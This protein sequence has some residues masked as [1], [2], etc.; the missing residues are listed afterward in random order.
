VIEPLE[1][2]ANTV[3]S[4]ID[5]SVGVCSDIRLCAIGNKVCHV[6]PFRLRAV[7]IIGCHASHFHG[8]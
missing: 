3:W 2:W 5:T 6:S 8:Y 4:D 1:G 7:G